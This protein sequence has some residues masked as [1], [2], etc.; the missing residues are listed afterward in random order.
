M[1]WADTLVELS[2]NMFTKSTLQDILSV[3]I[4]FISTIN[5]S[6]ANTLPLIVHVIYGWSSIQVFPKLEN[7]KAT[8]LFVQGREATGCGE[9]GA[10]PQEGRVNGGGDEQRERPQPRY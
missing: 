6:W 7:T 1:Q 3:S 8:S 2:G 4:L 9:G 10:I 5:C